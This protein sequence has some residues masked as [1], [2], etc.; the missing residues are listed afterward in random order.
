VLDDAHRREGPA[1]RPGP[2]HDEHHARR[3]LG[4]GSGH[5]S[6][7]GQ[8]LARQL[9]GCPDDRFLAYLIALGYPEGRPLAPIQRPGR[10]PVPGRRALGPL[11]GGPGQGRW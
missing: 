2:G 6:L 11:V 10:R 4:I 5:A 8:D 7:A 9:L 3:E 1:L